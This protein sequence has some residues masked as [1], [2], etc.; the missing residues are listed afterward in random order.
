MKPPA[1]VT[2]TLGGMGH[3]AFDVE[4]KIYRTQICRMDT[5]SFFRIMGHRFAGWTQILLLD[6][7]DTDTS[8]RCATQYK[9]S[10]CTQIFF[11]LFL[12]CVICEICV[13]FFNPIQVAFAFVI[14]GLSLYLWFGAEIQEKADFVGGGFQVIQ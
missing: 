1:P 5:D 7:W 6:L 11:F 14:I 9:F 3:R 13:L 4:E 10:G 8:I 12:I 2:R